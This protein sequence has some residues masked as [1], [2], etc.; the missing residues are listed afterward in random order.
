MK[1]DIDKAIKEFYPLYDSET[2]S[3]LQGLCAARALSLLHKHKKE[4]GV[5]EVMELSDEIL[6]GIYDK[7]E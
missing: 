1:T 6:T 2:T 3:D 5:M 4:T 7:V